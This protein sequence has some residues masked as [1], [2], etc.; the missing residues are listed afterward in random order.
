MRLVSRVKVE[1]ANTN[2]VTAGST[3][4]LP[5]CSAPSRNEKLCR[6]FTVAASAANLQ[7]TL[8]FGL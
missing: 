1:V 5:G 2:M 6:E 7:Q 3:T 8:S 4:S